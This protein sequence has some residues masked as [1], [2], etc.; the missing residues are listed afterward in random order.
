MEKKIQP[1][2]TLGAQAGTMVLDDVFTL[3]HP[4]FY[5]TLRR[6]VRVYDSSCWVGAFRYHLK[7]RKVYCHDTAI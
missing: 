2:L 4:Q 1:D 5:A 3:I 7:L 6:P